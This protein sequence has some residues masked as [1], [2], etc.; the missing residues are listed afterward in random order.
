LIELNKVAGWIFSP[1]S[2][3][4][5][6][7]GL[8]IVFTWLGRKRVSIVL[9]LFGL[10]WLWLVS[11]PLVAVSL[12][13]YLER[14]FPALKANQLPHA[15]AALIL[16]GGVG[17]AHSPERPDIHLHAGAD[18][19]WFAADLYRSGKVAWVLISGGN[20]PGIERLQSSAEATLKMLI[21]LGVPPSAIRLE[22]RSRNTFENAQFSLDLIRNV[23][24]KRVLLVTSA[25]HMPR[26]LRH[27]EI[28]LRDTDVVVIPASTDVEGLQDTLHPIGRYFPDAASL[29]LST[30]ALKEHL[31]FLAVLLAHVIQH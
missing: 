21:A 13:E 25:A 7:W 22:D 27:L 31:G 11:T 2:L 20:R 28:A 6:T 19:V 4:M 30:R 1:L 10:V 26:A 23:G 18:R 8:A 24:A 12:S 3:A 9:G 29:D 5:A 15:D 16:G 17:G 14:Q